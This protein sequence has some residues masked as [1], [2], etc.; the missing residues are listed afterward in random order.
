M[1]QK[2]F[3]AGETIIEEGDDGD[4][5]YVID[6]GD[7]DCFRGKKMIYQY[8]GSGAFGELAI[9]Y[10]APRAAT[11]KAATQVA[12]WTLERRA[13]KALTMS[14]TIAQRAKHREFLNQVDLFQEMSDYELMTM[15]DALEERVFHDGQVVCRQGDRGDVFYIVKQGTAV[16]TQ[17]DAKGTQVEVARLKTGTYFGEIALLTPKPRQATVIAD[18]DLHVLT[19]DRKSF[20]RVMGPLDDILQR[21]MTHYQKFKLGQI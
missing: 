19:W 4:F 20:T 2:V 17:L 18:G 6:N 7:V 8:R 14:S 16:C 12:C 9:M 15:A 21:N 3:E 10:N 11:C 5:F 1:D 13:F